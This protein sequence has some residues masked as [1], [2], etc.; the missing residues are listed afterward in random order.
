MK[1]ISYES[2]KFEFQEMKLTENIADT[3]W[4]YKYGWYDVDGDGVHD[5]TEEQIHLEQWGSCNDVAVGLI[6]YLAQYDISVSRKE[7][8]ENS[9]S[10]IV[11]PIVS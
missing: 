3:C 10:A 5:A 2:P 9:H 7:V 8:G 4:G 6:E 1:K 11:R